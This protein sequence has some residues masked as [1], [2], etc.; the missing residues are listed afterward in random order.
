MAVGR[1]SRRVPAWLGIKPLSIAL[2]FRNLSSQLS[3][4]ASS[5][6]NLAALVARWPREDP[7]PISTP[8]PAEMFS[9]TRNV[10]LLTT[11]PKWGSRV[12]FA[13]VKVTSFE[14]PWECDLLYDCYISGSSKRY[15]PT[16]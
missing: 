3:S 8:Q 2:V 13:G 1:E 4:G 14:L 6:R 15:F 9:N 16:L 5:P 11:A 7:L 10:D 12:V